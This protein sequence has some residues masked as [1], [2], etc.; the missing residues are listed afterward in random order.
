MRGQSPNGNNAWQ[1][2]KQCPDI[3]RLF[4]LLTFAAWRIKMFL[5][6]PHGN[7]AWEASI[8]YDFFLAEAE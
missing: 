6:C 8:G 4:V 1:I 5:I 7:S 2:L 3:L